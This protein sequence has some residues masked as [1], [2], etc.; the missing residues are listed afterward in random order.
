M[1]ERG[2]QYF[3]P[4][5]GGMGVP[6]TPAGL[7][8]IYNACRRLYPE[9]PNPLQV[10]AVVKYWLG[11]PD[12]LDYISMYANPGDPDR[13]IPPHWHYISFGL[14]DLHGDGRVHQNTGP[15]SPSGFGFELTLRLKREPGETA[16]P[17]WPAALLQALARYVFQSENTLCSG[18]HVSWHAPL[19]NS[20]SRVQ[21]ML[22]TDDPQLQPITTPHGIVNFVQIVG[23]CSEEL[24]A[25]QHWNGAGVIE[26][27]KTIPI[28][29]GPWLITEMRRG[30]TV[31]EIDPTLQDRVDQGIENE[32]SN[33]SGVS[34]RCAWEEPSDIDRHDKVNEEEN[35]ENRFIDGDRRG[36]SDI[37]RPH[38]SAFESEQIKATLKKGLNTA[39]QIKQEPV[40]NEYSP[41]H[42][43][44]QQTGG[45]RKESFDSNVSSE[46]PSE[47]CRTRTLDA[48]HLKFNV[49]AGSLLPLALRGRLKHGRHFTFKSALND[50]AITLV[51]SSVLGAIVDEEHPYGA[52]G[53]WLQVLFTDDF[54]E[55]LLVQMEE[56]STPENIHP[57]KVYSWPEKRLCITIIPDDL[58][59]GQS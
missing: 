42:Q 26:L 10:T 23:C 49:E 52:H 21:H 2:E 33:L 19:D 55:R 48:V 17:T 53:P 38:I 41:S 30:E 25:A 13:N 6:V 45:S 16:P 18:D 47:L 24:K 29:G 9:Q 20:D 11:G 37:E 27:L 12:P 31:F 7:E 46:G 44:D 1:E 4:N 22:M 51:S 58:P 40:D 35:K 28:A 36:S 8:A 57:P 34:A 56:L 3:A 54:V 59:E 50:V 43:P 15:E 32:G 5:F 39:H 14:S